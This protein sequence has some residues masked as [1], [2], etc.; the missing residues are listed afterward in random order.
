M[1]NKYVNQALEICLKIKPDDKVVVITDLDKRELGTLF[2]TSA[3]ELSPGSTHQLFIMEDFGKREA[4]NPIKFPDKIREAILNSDVSI[5]AAQG[6]PGELGSFRIPLLKTIKAS[7]K[8]RHGHMPNVT[9][10]ILEKGFGADYQKVVDLTHEIFAKVKNA[11]TAHITS[12]LG[13]DLKIEFNPDYNWV[14]SDAIIQ[15]GDYGN[16]PSGEVFTCVE[17]CEGRIIID[18][19]V[20]DYLC[21]KYGTL[22]NNPVEVVIKEG[23]AAT[24]ECKNSELVRD[25]EAYFMIDNNANRVGEFAIGTNINLDRFIGNLLLDEKFPGIHIAFGSG[26]P[27]KTGATWDGKAHL[28][29]IVTK[30][31]VVID[32]NIIMKKG[33]FI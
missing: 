31:T 9:A 6:K 23:R 20:G 14:A 15:K 16:I 11:K 17:S 12:D 21:E 32:E 29:C 2:Y 33:E 26:Y 13:T 24:I 25:L 30:P 22:E 1:T 3:Q 7:K 4:D 5:Y 8:V 27:D 19:E 28:D 10:E 18:G